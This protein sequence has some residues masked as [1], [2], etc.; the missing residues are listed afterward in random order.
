MSSGSSPARRIDGRKP[1]RRR[2]AGGQRAQL[3]VVRNLARRRL[4]L[5]GI[6]RAPVQL[7]AVRAGRDPG[8][9]VLGVHA[10]SLA[11]HCTFA[12]YSAT[13]VDIT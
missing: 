11:K 5:D 10:A 12:Q 4:Q 9:V 3:G 1:A 6:D 7:E 2:Q 13:L 8:F